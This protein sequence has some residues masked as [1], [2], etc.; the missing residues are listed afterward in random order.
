MCVFVCVCVAKCD[1]ALRNTRSSL[2][3]YIIFCMIYNSFIFDAFLLALTKTYYTHLVDEM[4]FLSRLG[5]AYMFVCGM[6][7]FL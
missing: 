3:R 7:A 6:C 4:K 5:R 1:H 2:H